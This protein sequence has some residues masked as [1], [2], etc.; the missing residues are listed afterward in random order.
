MSGFGNVLSYL[1]S[2]WFFIGL[3]VA[4][5]LVTRVRAARV[6]V[7]F[8]LGL[9]PALLMLLISFTA[10]PLWR[11]ASWVYAQTLGRLKLEGITERILR[12]RASFSKGALIAGRRKDV[13]REMWPEK[14]FPYLYGDVPR[15][16]E[17]P[18]WEDGKLVGGY[19]VAWLAD[20]HFTERVLRSAT[21]VALTAAILLLLLPVGY[22]FY[23]LVR[24]VG[25]SVYYFF[26][27]PRPVL[28]V[29]PDG[30]EI[31]YGTWSW[32]KAS[33]VTAAVEGYDRLL[34]AGHVFLTWVVFAVGS[35]LLLLVVSI[36]KWFAKT[37]APYE[38]VT[39]DAS[40]RWAFRA[41]ARDVINETYS[42]QFQHATGYLENAKLYNLGTGTGVLRARGDLTAPMGGQP[43][44]LDSESLSQHL[45]VL[46]G[47]GEGKTSAVLRP[48]M[49]QIFD[50]PA[51]GAY[52]CDA[53]GV[54]WSDAA[55]VAEKAG[56]AE[57]TI[58]IGSG[59][60]QYG[61]DALAGLTPSTV[62][63]VL[64]SV[65]QQLSG[66]GPADSFWPD[67]ASNFLRHVLTVA[68]AYA[69]TDDAKAEV[70]VS[71]V[72][73][74]SLWWAYQA[75]IDEA[76][77]T[78]A[79]ESIRKEVKQR[80]DRIESAPPSERPAL[81]EA[82]RPLFRP[83]VQA[84]LEYIGGAWSEMATATKTGIVANVTQLLDPLAGSQ[85]IRERFAV[86]PSDATIDIAQALD[87]K[88]VLNALS[89]I[90][91]GLAARLINILLKTSLYRSARLREAQMKSRGEDAKSKPCAFIVDE[92]QEIVTSDPSS[93]LSD[94]TFWNV[95]RSTGLV[96]IFATQTVAALRQALG[97]H[98]AENF[99]QQTRSKIFF[100]SEDKDTIEYACWCA[101]TFERGRVYADDQRESIEYRQI[102][103]NWHPL[104]ES[105]EMEI[106][107]G[108][109]LFFDVAK[110]LLF[111]L[112][113][114]IDVASSR[115]NFSPDESHVPGRYIGWGEGSES[116]AQQT[117]LARLS[118]QQ[119]ASWRA[120]DLEREYRMEGNERMP[121]LTPI[122]LITMGRWH[123]Y[124]HIQR[125]G[126]TRQDIMEVKHVFE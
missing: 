47:T 80:R 25:Q 111:P 98:A 101:G 58:V 126:C 59:E 44:M 45:L 30:T 12:F 31:H 34:S 120:E 77:L 52:V 75:V 3:I 10:L 39:K 46:G 102:I 1:Q 8:V 5:W 88:L 24:D 108:A 114:K 14:R 41:E 68:A 86:G 67:M 18:P 26:A 21:Q 95:A 87:G 56:R 72:A 122:D 117:H 16:L 73:P 36:K 50:D 54:L 20:R 105:P 109:G 60:G 107:G 74:Y 4:V 49:Q 48:L 125:A 11:V 53:K 62:A 71:K 40:V 81:I 112:S 63:A 69:L 6:F 124:A 104:L 76:K 51:F 94:A 2:P 9:L 84:S 91:G 92:V 79:I 93:G 116:I 99:L 110:G 113:E 66:D 123:A 29:W 90:E 33:V 97:D 15:D 35:S 89:S 121:A 7:M 64:R 27:E 57:D 17:R 13:A 19:S 23:T 83:D 78:K 85:S 22:L 96:G 100:R 43:V 32:I 82:A 118:A 38:F 119:A 70:A 37:A 28:E 61:V 106:E 65:L 42:K 55:D 103:D 115:A